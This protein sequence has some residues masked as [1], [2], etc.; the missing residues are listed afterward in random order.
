MLTALYFSSIYIRY[1]TYSVDRWLFWFPS[2]QTRDAIWVK[3][4]LCSSSK[5]PK[6]VSRS[7]V[8]SDTKYEEEYN[9]GTTALMHT[10]STAIKRI[11]LKEI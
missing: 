5:M 6:V 4:M 8:C 3:Q 10:L 1:G 11:I 2:N 9:Q 7:I